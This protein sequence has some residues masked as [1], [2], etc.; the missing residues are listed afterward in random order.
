MSVTFL[1]CRT[2]LYLFSRGGAFGALLG[3]RGISRRWLV[4]G[5][6]EPWTLENHFARGDDL[7]QCFLAALGAGL[8][9][10]IGEGL[11]AFELHS[12]I[13]ASISVDGHTFS[14]CFL[15]IFLGYNCGIIAP[16]LG[17][18]KP[19]EAACYNFLTISLTWHLVRCEGTR[20][21]AVYRVKVL[22][23]NYAKDWDRLLCGL[24]LHQPSRELGTGIVER[25]WARHWG[26][27]SCSFGRRQVRGQ[28]ER[29]VGLLQIAD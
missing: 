13:L 17:C 16:L 22:W 26:D 29:G 6:I 3:R 4:V 14:P 27:H 15:L 7:F 10:I 28:R 21:V 9:W 19:S 8:Q 24:T 11:L 23:S 20:K 2:R 18:G 12:A 1:I 25:L 5:G